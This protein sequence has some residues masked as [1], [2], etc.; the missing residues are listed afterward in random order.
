M[1][2]LAA[3]TRADS[4][5]V[6]FKIKNV[7]A[8]TETALPIF[9]D[10]DCYGRGREAIAEVI[11]Q[12]LGPILSDEEV[13]DAI[14]ESCHKV[15][16]DQPLMDHGQPWGGRFYGRDWS[17]RVRTELY[18]PVEEDTLAASFGNGG[19][20]NTDFDLDD[21]EATVT[22]ELTGVRVEG[23]ATFLHPFNKIITYSATAIV[24]GLHGS[25]DV[26]LAVDGSEVEITEIHEDSIDLGFDEDGVDFEFETNNLLVAG[27]A[28]VFDV[29]ID[30]G[31]GVYGLASGDCT[32]T[33]SCLL[34]IFDQIVIENE[35]FMGLQSP[36]LLDMLTDSLNGALATPI[37]LDEQ[38][39]AGGFDA[40]VDV[41][42]SALTSS[43]TRN[44]M[45]AS[46]AI[47]LDSQSAGSCATGLSG[48]TAPPQPRRARTRPTCS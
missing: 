20:V 32:N 14:D 12:A 3:T 13:E 10:Y 31:M 48:H 36:D 21:A 15:I 17:A 34:A 18:I 27:I 26:S 16:I 29:V 4:H 38:I 33:E 24:G 7:S 30:V 43:A 25:V 23:L 45:T 1:G 28:E 9:V 40:D 41:S 44:D 22:I 19:R 39:E 42:L 35:A 46:F 37:A 8:L 47:E 2:P 5:N 6:D 11:E